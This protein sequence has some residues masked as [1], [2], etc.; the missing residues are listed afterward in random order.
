MSLSRSNQKLTKFVDTKRNVRPSITKV[1]K[2]P[3]NTLIRSVGFSRG[4]PIHFGKFQPELIGVGQG[5][6]SNMLVFFSKSTM[7]FD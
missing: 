3:N 7:Y 4:T 6:E 1:L 2:S 5:F